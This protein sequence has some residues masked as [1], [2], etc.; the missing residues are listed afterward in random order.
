MNPQNQQR[1]RETGPTVGAVTQADRTTRSAGLDRTVTMTSTEAQNRFGR[2]LD[3]VARDGIV[4]ITKHNT[5]RAVVISA[6]RYKALTRNESPSLDLLTTEFDEML[7]RMQT[8]EV[9]AG[10]QAAF[11]A[12]PDELG[13]AAVA[14]ATRDRK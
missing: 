5:T 8:P 3:E 10:M 2:M 9:R 6:D 12:S 13:R 7:A 4:L 11:D 1:A 14:A